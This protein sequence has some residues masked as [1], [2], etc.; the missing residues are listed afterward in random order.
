MRAQRADR[1]AD[2]R[3][4]LLD[5]AEE[6]FARDGVT[7][8]TTRDLV[9]AADQRNASAVS[10][11]FGSRDGLL[12]ALLARRGA[13]VDA[14]RGLLRAQLPPTPGPDSVRDLI[15][16]L[17]VPYCELLELPQGRSYLRIVA[18]LRGRFS[19]WRVES[20]SASTEHLARI[21]DEIEA[22]IDRDAPVRR[23]RIVALMVV[24]TAT[25]AE[26][27][28]HLDESRQ[29]GLDHDGFV[30]NLIDMCSALV[31]S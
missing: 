31:T 28:R 17:V 7:G 9:A 23:E 24:L 12:A 3:E 14:A 15:S 30:S 5:V 10:Y 25:T 8:V 29:P 16:C 20:D 19:E 4:R 26:R 18:Q 22:S 2:T 13:P 11:H 27:A 21:I 6:R 1:S